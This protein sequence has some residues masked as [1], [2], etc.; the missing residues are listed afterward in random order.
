MLINPRRLVYIYVALVILEGALRKWLLPQELNPLI[1]IARD[2][3]A[4]ALLWYGWRRGLLNPAWL[5]LFWLITAGLLAA[6][7]VLSMLTTSIPINIWVYGLRTNLLHFPLILIIP[8]LLNQD[9]L[10]KL[11]K[12]LLALALPIALMMLWQ[13]RSPLSSWI[14]DG[15]IEGVAQIT[16]VVDKVRPPG[17]FSYITGAAEYFA[18]INGIILGSWLDRRLHIS[19]IFYGLV[20]TILAVSV[21]GSRLLLATV[22]VVWVGGL[23]LRMIRHFRLPS[24][25]SLLSLGL[26]GM[27]AI[28]LLEFSPLGSLVD[29]GWATT[30]ER[31]DSANAYDGGVIK[32]FFTTISLPQ[33]ALSDIPLFGHGLGL[34]TNFGAKVLTGR[35]GFV[36]AENEI[37]RVI[38]E[39][40]LLIG[41]VFL[42]FRLAMAAYVFS[43]AWQSLGRLQQLPI[44]LMFANFTTLLFGQIGR[45]TSMGFV[46]LCMAFSL[47]AAR[48]GAIKSAS[49]PS[50]Q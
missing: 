12:R 45:P 5:R 28:L 32:R 24:L 22:A 39:S 50:R 1:A 26:V 13:Y 3:V 43:S 49:S 42:L 9:D 40:G 33:N 2:P 23:G 20:A 14:N 10:N 44:S 30:S 38:F 41:G 29:E 35:V 18:L 15:A 16:A 25:G 47:T 31:F 37:G 11:L 4:L 19:W 34:G 21:S 6:G 7:G 36:L 48:L 8:G 46:V 27:A 17:P